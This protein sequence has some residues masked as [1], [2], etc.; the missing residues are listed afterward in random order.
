VPA[1][2]GG[3]LVG[4]GD[5]G[6]LLKLHSS[7]A[8]RCNLGLAELDG[9]GA[10]VEVELLAAGAAGSETLARTT[11][12]VPPAG[13]LQVN[14]VFEAMG[15]TAEHDA[16]LARVNV[17][18]GGRILAYASNVDNLTGDAELIPAIRY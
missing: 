12:T 7:A 13:L 9:S 14:R 8:T 6:W 15:V 2:T 10:V 1:L 18:S 17:V 3:D 11:F 5:T 16:A 4:P